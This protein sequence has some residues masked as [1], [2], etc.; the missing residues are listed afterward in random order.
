MY[1]RRFNKKVIVDIR[2]SDMPQ[3]GK[4]FTAQ[5]NVCGILVTDNTDGHGFDFR[6]AAIYFGHENTQMATNKYKYL[7][8]ANERQATDFTDRHGFKRKFSGGAVDY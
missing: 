2:Q 5:K 8:A 3:R 4:G 1:S 7:P 6:Y